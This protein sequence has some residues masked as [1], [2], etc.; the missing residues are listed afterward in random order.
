MKNLKKY[1]DNLN[2]I[3]SK[4][5][6]YREKN[7]MSLQNLSDELMLIGIDIPKSSLQNIE[8]GKR[9][10]REYELYAFSKVFNISMEYLLEDFIKDIQELNQ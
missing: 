3:G 9:I 10:V 1:N 8:N 2:V 4:I 6:E 7:K 5:R